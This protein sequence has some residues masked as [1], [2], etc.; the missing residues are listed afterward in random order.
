MPKNKKEKAMVADQ[1]TETD[2]SS[3]EESNL[4]SENEEVINL[5]LMATHDSEATTSNSI[6]KVDRKSV[7]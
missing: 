5:V 4:E 3:A 1:Q 7:V 2:Y 6:V